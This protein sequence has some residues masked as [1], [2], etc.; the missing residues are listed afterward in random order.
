MIVG[1]KRRKMVK[2]KQWLSFAV[3]FYWFGFNVN[4]LVVDPG[5]MLI[6]LSQA[7]GR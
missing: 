1:I 4:Q 6:H 3:Y 5:V 2:Q 7:N